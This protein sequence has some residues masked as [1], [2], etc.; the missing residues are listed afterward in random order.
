MRG[1]FGVRPG[2]HLPNRE[3]AS[4]TSTDLKH[5]CP[6][7]WKQIDPNA[8]T[9]SFCLSQLKDYDALPF[10]TKLL[11]ALAHLARETR[12]LAIQQLGE[13]GSLPALAAFRDILVT[14]GDPD[15][16]VAIAL[17]TAPHWRPRSTRA[18]FRLEA[19]QVRASEECR[20]AAVEMNF[21]MRAPP[22]GADD[23]I[24]HDDRITGL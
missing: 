3:R 22:R 7:C 20:R 16:V 19:S 21:C 8:G 14:E 18:A 17:A 4:R 1:H 13:M 6:W 2:H 24:P 15:V 23:V 11:L 9:C 10:E 12:M 5:L